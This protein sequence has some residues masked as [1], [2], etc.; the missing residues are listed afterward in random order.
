[1]ALDRGITA[2]RLAVSLAVLL[3]LA[4][5]RAAPTNDEVRIAES[6]ADALGEAL[7]TTPPPLPLPSRGTVMRISPLTASTASR[8]SMRTVR[9]SQ[10][11]PVP[12]RGWASTLPWR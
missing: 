7:A 6:Y 10:T 8:S 5:C 9:D 4:A 12:R 2:T 3:L 1:M 11:T